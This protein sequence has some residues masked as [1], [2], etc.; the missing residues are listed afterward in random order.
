MS[1]AESSSARASWLQSLD[2]EDLRGPIEDAAARFPTVG[3]W[4]DL[5]RASSTGDPAELLATVNRTLTPHRRF[6]DYRQANEYA[7]DGLDTVDLLAGNALQATPALIPVIERAI[8]LATRAI[9]KSDDSSGAQGGLVRT[10]LDAHA[11]A[12]RTATPPLTQSEQ[13]RLVAWIVKY[14]YGGTQDFFDPDI[15]A[16]APGLSQK[17]IEKYRQAI[18]DTDLGRYGSYPL[19][20][21]AVLDQDR[22]AIITA[23]GG[24][25]HNAMVAARIVSDLDEAGLRQDAIAYAHTG[26]AMDARGWDAKLVTFLVDDALTRGDTRQAVTLRR[27]WFERFPTSRS[28]TMLRDTAPSSQKPSTATDADPPASTPSPEL[29]SPPDADPH[30]TERHSPRPGCPGC[31]GIDP[32][33]TQPAQ[34]TRIMTRPG[35]PRRTRWARRQQ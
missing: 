21:L 22:D 27:D 24:E 3:D 6:Y 30:S 19:T 26:I 32:R 14:R 15:V 13:T 28:F 8:T 1:V 23:N 10:L 16:Y 18:A 2:A 12:T 5:H 4:L 34:S 29:A 9:L 35:L 17:S 20:R 31:R 7:D 33:R 25:P 11:T